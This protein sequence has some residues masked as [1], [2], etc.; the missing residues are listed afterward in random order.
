MS[1]ET[2]AD[3]SQRAARFL[4]GL[5]RAGSRPVSMPTEFAPQSEA[6]AYRV[7]RAVA[8][9]LGDRGG[10]W[11]VAMANADRGTCAPVLA[12]SVQATGSRFDSPISDRPGIEPE[13][14]FRL[15]RALPPLGPGERYTRQQVIA[16]I[17]NAHAAIEIVVSRF[18]HHNT[19]SP[20]DRLAD[21]ISNAG[22]ILGPACEQ[23]QALEYTRLP[24]ELTITQAK[25]VLLSHRAHG[26]HPLRDPL[27]PMIWLANH[28]SALG[29]G[30]QADDVVTTGSYAGL[31]EMQPGSHLVA[32]FEGLGAVELYS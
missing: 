23:W 15:K 7:Q 20:L 6:D 12:A 5:R 18:Q 10:Y 26:G 3:A 29:T 14:A 27:L 2:G 28:L 19:T 25:Q 22:L 16:A 11:K 32:A 24:L 17:G 30:M 21:K 4:I 8:V 13:I 1:F 31:H 9:E